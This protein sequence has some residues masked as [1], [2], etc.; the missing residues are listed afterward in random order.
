[1]RRWEE[2]DRGI[3]RAENG[4]Y[5]LSPEKRTQQK[6]AREEVQ[7]NNMVLGI[8]FAVWGVSSILWTMGQA[9]INV[10]K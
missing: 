3:F 6:Q 4:T 1:M 9:I 2:E 7:K 5:T 8:A 10:I